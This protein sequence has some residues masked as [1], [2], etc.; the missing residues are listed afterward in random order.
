MLKGMPDELKVWA[1]H[2]DLSPSPP[3]F[4]VAATSNNAPVAV[5]EAPERGFYALLFHPEVA[6]TDRG[7]ELLRNFASMSAAAPVTGRS[8][9]SSTKQRRASRRRWGTAAWRAVC[10]AASTRRWP[11][12]Y[13]PRRRRSAAVHF[14]RQRPA[15]PQRSAAGHGALQEVAMPVHHVDASTPFL[16]RSRASPTRAEAQDHRQDLHRCFH[17]QCAAGC[18]DSSSAQGT[19]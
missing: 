15:S 10:R 14:R 9:R 8:G 7:K 1:S 19:L 13:P 12:R 11:R 4:A 5:M 17:R 16:D 2:G 3:G 6:H 18:G